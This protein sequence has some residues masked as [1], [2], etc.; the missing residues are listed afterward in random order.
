MVQRTLYRTLLHLINT[1]RVLTYY[2]SILFFLTIYLFTLYIVIIHGFFQGIYIAALMWSFFILCVPGGSSG[3][4]LRPIKLVTG[5]GI[6]FAEIIT[7]TS[8]IG[9][10]LYTHY[11]HSSIYLKSLGTHLLYRILTQPWPSWIIPF[12]CVLGTLYRTFLSTRM[13]AHN[14]LL[15]YALTAILAFA[16]ITVLILFSFRDLIIIMNI[17]ASL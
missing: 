11:Y 1:A 14:R 3:V 10:N 12:V 16:G 2:L 5:Y 9:L 13:Y 15:H 8:A 4:L 7:W 6:P 17:Q